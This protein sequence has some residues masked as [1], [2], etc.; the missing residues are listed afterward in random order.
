MSTLVDK[1]WTDLVIG[2]SSEVDYTPPAGNW[3]FTT[4]TVGCDIVVGSNSKSELYWDQ[5]GDG[6]NM[7]LIAAIYTSGLTY[8]LELNRNIVY[9]ADGNSRVVI[10]RGFFSGEG[11][12]QIYSRMQGYVL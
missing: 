2:F 8:D 10:R 7:Q 6:E 4:F 3:I 5:T 12:R 11:S 9:A 1:D